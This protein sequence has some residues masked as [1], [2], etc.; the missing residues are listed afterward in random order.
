MVR[1]NRKQET[2]ESFVLENVQSSTEANDAC[3]TTGQ[4]WFI[5]CVDNCIFKPDTSKLGEI[6]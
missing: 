4:A 5:H 2:L 1:P 3:A 6:V